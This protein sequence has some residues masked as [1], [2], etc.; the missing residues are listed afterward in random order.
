MPRKVV[1]LV[2][3]K[4]RQPTE[5]E[6]DAL[7]RVAEANASGIAGEGAALEPERPITPLAGQTGIIERPGRVLADGSRRGARTLR[8]MTCYLDPELGRR[9]RAHALDRGQSMS[10][11]IAE[12]LDAYL[13]RG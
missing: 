6:L 2:Q 9:L 3:R 7:E 5:V 4:P 1:N 8:R 12:A 13:G 10:D 11:V